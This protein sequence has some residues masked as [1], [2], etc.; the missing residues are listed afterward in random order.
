MK[1]EFKTSSEPLA[2]DFSQNQDG[3]L[4]QYLEKKLSGKIIE[5]K[6]PQF[7]LDVNGE[8]VRGSFFATKE[9]VD[10]RLPLGHYRLQELPKMRRI[11]DHGGAGALSSPMPGKVISVL[12]KEG[13]SVQKGDLLMVLEAMKMEH[14]ILAPQSGKIEKIFFKEGERVRQEVELLKM[15]ES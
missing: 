12:A 2:I 13:D 9:F 11:S 3:F 8:K 15:T 5:W 1:L 4:L 14:K 10:I 7:I 6:P